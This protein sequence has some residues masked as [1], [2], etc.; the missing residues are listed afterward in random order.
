MRLPPL[1]IEGFYSMSKLLAVCHSVGDCQVVFET[2]KELASQHLLTSILTVGA[3]ARSKIQA[4]LEGFNNEASKLISVIDI[5]DILPE[6]SPIKQN[7]LS[8]NDSDIKL[9]TEKID[10]ENFSA[11]LVGTPSYVNASVQCHIPEQL[12]T[13]WAPILHST[14]ISDYAFY[15]PEHS[16]SKNRWF[17]KA[18]QFLLPFT[19]AI[20]AFKASPETTAVVGHPSVD[21]SKALYLSWTKERVNGYDERFAAIREKL[22]IDHSEK[23]VFVAAGKAGDEAMVEALTKVIRLFPNIKVNLGMHP[24]ATEA[25]LKSIEQ[26]IID[27]KC[28]KQIKILPKGLVTTDEAVYAAEGV[29]TVS[30]T[31]GTQAAA[32]GRLSAFYQEGKKSDDPSVPYVVAEGLATFHAQAVELVPFFLKVN[33]SQGLMLETNLTTTTSAAKHIASKLSPFMKK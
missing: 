20:E 13:A 17:M 4:L 15:D 1:A 23:F 31:V 5:D 30:S 18:K 3:A 11:L 27:A 21:A 2:A 6:S 9:L 7:A 12:L 14:V 26:I 8:L 19:K 24:A 16:L 32:C 33:E 10:I 22:H 25:Y 28:D 29:I